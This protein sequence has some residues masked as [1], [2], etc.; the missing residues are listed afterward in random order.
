MQDD[1]TAI[2]LIAEGTAEVA[3]S[4]FEANGIA[5][6]PDVDIVLL[7]E[8]AIEQSIDLCAGDFAAEITPTINIVGQNLQA[9]GISY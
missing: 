4:F 8:F 5:L 7:I 2:Q 1:A 3:A 6:P 9:Q